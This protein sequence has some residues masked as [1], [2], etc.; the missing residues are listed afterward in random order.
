MKIRKKNTPGMQ[1]FGDKPLVK[2][3]ADGSPFAAIDRD[4][5]DKLRVFGS[6]SARYSEALK[7]LAK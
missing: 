4:K 1:A 7:E 2:S 5:Q 6:L 3:D